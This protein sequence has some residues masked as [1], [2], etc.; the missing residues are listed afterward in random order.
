[1][2]TLYCPKCGYN[3]TGLTED[4]CPE[5]GEKFSRAELAAIGG[6]KHPSIVWFLVVLTLLPIVFAVLV[7]KVFEPGAIQD[8]FGQFALVFVGIYV[9]LSLGSSIFTAR[10]IARRLVMRPPKSRPNLGSVALTIVFSLIFFLTQGF[11]VF[12]GFFVG[13][14]ANFHM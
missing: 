14:A 8:M 5:C 4:R 12:V 7:F 10:N 2:P 1:M 9:L 13:C 3:L 11:L 6:I